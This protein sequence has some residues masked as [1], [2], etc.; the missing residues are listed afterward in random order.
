M[1]RMKLKMGP[2]HGFGFDAD[3]K[4]MTNLAGDVQVG[5]LLSV[6]TAAVTA[7]HGFEIEALVY[8]CHILGMSIETDCKQDFGFIVDSNIVTDP[9]VYAEAWL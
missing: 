9:A 1:L 7:K 8:L 3:S 2:E 6:S 5:I 4:K